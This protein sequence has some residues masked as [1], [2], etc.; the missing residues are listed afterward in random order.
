MQSC[1]RPFKT[2]QNH[3]W[4]Y[5]SIWD[6]T[7]LY[8]DIHYHIRPYTQDL[9]R[10]LILPS[11]PEKITSFFPVENLYHYS[12][13]FC[14]TQFNPIE[15][16]ASKFDRIS[17]HF[18]STMALISGDLKKEGI[19][20]HTTAGEGI[21]VINFWSSRILVFLIVLIVLTGLNEVKQG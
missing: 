5:T 21:V 3:A 8:E 10:S 6:L 4:P 18:I 7:E 16:W 13:K 12:D 2:I 11:D 17:S 19:I 1:V 9:T 15:M 20:L 14:I